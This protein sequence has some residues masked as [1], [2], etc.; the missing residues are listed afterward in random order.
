MLPKQLTSLAILLSTVSSVSAITYHADMTDADSRALGSLQQFDSGVQ[1]V[2]GGTVCSG[3]M[4]NSEWALFASHCFA[5]VDGTRVTVRYLEDDATIAGTAYVFDNESPTAT[6][7]GDTVALVKL[8]NP[9]VQADRW[10]APYDQFDE[11]GQLA[12]QTGAGR[13]GFQGTG[14]NDLPS[15][16]RRFRAVSQIVSNTNVN[17]LFY[18]WN[19]SPEVANPSP[20]TTRFEGA[21]APGD[22]GGSLFLYSRGRFFS[23][24]TVWAAIPGQG[25]VNNRLSTHV[26]EIE[27]RSQSEFSPGLSFAYPQPLIPVATWVAED[28][29]QANGTT[30][31]SW[32]DRFDDKSFSNTTDG[33]SGLPLFV[34]NATPTGLAAVAFDGDDAMGLSAAENPV[35]G[36]TSFSVVMVVRNSSGGAGLQTT[37]F[38][39]TGVLDAS[40]GDRSWG[41]SYSH[42]DRYGFSIEAEDDS[43]TGLFRG[44]SS[45]GSLADGQWHVV[46]ATWDGSEILRDNAGDDRNMKLYV[47]SIDQ[48]RTGQGAYHFNTAREAVALLLGKSQTNAEAGFDGEIAEL[49]LYTGELQMH[50]VDRILETMRE[51]Y[52]TS[53]PGAVFDRPWS[54]AIEV[55]AGQDLS[56]RGILTGGAT[57]STWEVISGTGP[58]TF[59][60][61]D[62]PNTDVIFAEPGSY[63]LRLVAAKGMVTGN[64]DIFVDVYIPD[65]ESADATARSV[66][67]NWI[68][69]DIGT[70]ATGGSFT[71]TAGQFS[72]IGSGDG[73]GNYV[74]ETYDHGQ[75]TWKGV[76]GDFDWIARLSSMGNATGPTRAGLMLRGGP[77][78]TDAAVFI[79]YAPDGKLYWMSRQDGGY[80]GDLVVDDTPLVSL[81]AYLKIE[82]RDESVSV[83]ISSDGSSFT[84]V[85][86]SDVALPGVVR[87]GFFVAS[88]DST[89]PITA[90][91]DNLSLMQIGYAGGSTV[92]LAA[93]N[94][95]PGVIE[96]DPEL[97]GADEP[98][99]Q[100][101]QESGPSVLNFSKNYNGNRQVLRAP[102]STAGVYQTRLTVDDGNTET[103]RF[104]EESITYY[105]RYDFKTDGNTESW[106]ENN[107]SNL[108]AT[109][110]VLAGT[111]DTTDPQVTRSG[112]S[113]SGTGH[114]QVTVRMR[115]SSI[116]GEVQLYWG[117][118]GA[119]GFSGD[120]VASLN[121]SGSNAFQTLVF[122][123]DGV[124]EWDGETITALRIDPVNGASASGAT[125]EIDYIEISDGQAPPANPE[126]TD[127]NINGD[128]QGWSSSKDLVSEY[129]IGGR[130][131]AQ[132]TGNDPI[133]NKDFDNLRADSVEALV[134]RLKLSNAGFLQ[135]FWATTD[136]SGFAAVRSTTISVAGTGSWETVRL[137][138]AGNLEWD[139]TTITKLRLDP[140]NQ[141]ATDLEIDAIV[142]SAGD[143]DEDQIPDAYEVSSGLDALV[144][145]SAGDLDGDGLLN[146]DEYIAGT[147]A[148]DAA[149]R[150]TFISQ[151]LTG[152]GFEV[153][154]SGKSGRSYTL[155][156]KLSLTDATWIPVDTLGPLGSDQSITLDDATSHDKA[157]YQV[158]VTFP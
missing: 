41:L 5:F 157:F 74:G 110:G 11:V 68:S 90:V 156:R 37:E 117:R 66:G 116:N 13:Y 58:V 128:F 158:E 15:S 150:L 48:I 140:I 76:A 44:G 123:M 42:N 98:W 132:T 70:S 130:Y 53:A 3:S 119:G 89:T 14:G 80:W 65:A 71:E 155:L 51:R 152:A 97:S 151:Q 28:L 78:P 67:G 124:S 87:T 138:L 55:P 1:I 52:I 16:D 135:L 122:N 118:T 141:N 137:P 149:E 56:L 54:S 94:T 26:D 31:T 107:V 2:A 39:T 146:G 35:A 93:N 83:F 64:E 148:N 88:G 47:D 12:W 115:S 100:A 45:N 136:A 99:L 114:T 131:V 101:I 92:D 60:N 86:D 96:Y 134:V 24:S 82:R 113:L 40:S 19:G 46:V 6:S 61:F 77:G 63:H 62:S 50:E 17:Y 105:T 127:F 147:A 33:G 133:L 8:D 91:F 43:V 22:S 143:A 73:V 104:L 34:D 85:G 72:V 144:D 30:V 20:N 153:V 10:V 154:L 59:T 79:G 36:S 125:F 142:L 120:R 95:S 23:A 29:A 49:R 106:N 7:N 75:F 112:L 38:G 57:T 121:Y 18:Q 111:A 129:V 139:G 4:L 69:S 103:Y 84:K 109:L 21:T 81:P 108:D 32:L 145:D 126:V 102:A 9:I 25:L 27:A